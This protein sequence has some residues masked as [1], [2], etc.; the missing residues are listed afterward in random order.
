MDIIRDFSLKGDRSIF[1]QTLSAFICRKEFDKLC[2]GVGI[3]G[4]LWWE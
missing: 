3:S 1:I 4:V 2:S